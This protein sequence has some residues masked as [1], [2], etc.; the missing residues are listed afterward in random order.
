MIHINN[1][2]KHIEYWKLDK[3]DQ[4]KVNKNNIIGL[5]SNRVTHF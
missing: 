4:E 5:S 3:K 2:C 1:K